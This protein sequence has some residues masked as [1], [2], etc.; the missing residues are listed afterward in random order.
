MCTSEVIFMGQVKKIRMEL[1]ER[2]DWPN[3]LEHKYVCTRHFDDPYLNQILRRY[4]EKEE[5]VCS[6]CGRRGAVCS[7]QALMEQVAWKIHMY[8]D[9]INNAGLYYADSFYDD[10][11][12]IIAGFKRVGEYVAP[13]EAEYY[14]STRA[15]MEDLGLYTE[16]EDLNEDIE[17][18]FT[19]QE[20]IE[21]DIL[22]E[23]YGKTLLNKWLGFVRI[24]TH[25]RRFTFL[26]TPEFMPLV[27]EERPEKEMDILSSLRLLII[28]QKLIRVLP[29]GVTL[30]RARRV[31]EGKK[32]YGFDDITSAPD[33]LAS[34]NRMSPAG[35][36]MFYSSFCMETA[37]TECL[38][39][40]KEA[41]IL[42]E[43]STMRDLRVLDL[44]K[45]PGPS[46]WMESW[47]ENQFLHSFNCEVTKRLNPEDS[48][49]LQYIPTQVFTEY[50]RYMFV[51]ENGKKIDGVVYGSAK[52]REQN[53]VLFCNQKE[54]YKYV[55]LRNL[56]CK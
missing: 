56:S 11:S 4:G 10:E 33:A 24:V 19:T 23:D 40:D 43:F 51:D 41:L 17:D 54:S 55:Y 22:H 45:I 34:I 21:R 52:T 46:F 37:A 2:G 48:N 42:G 13:V 27:T 25:S 6:Y 1:E 44:T 5:R 15:L 8:Y 47:Q 3:G 38:G 29:K 50:L 26:A 12:E 53:V 31:R 36:S 39:D 16:D 14:D 20:W 49:Q 9:D 7:M 18:T 35:I 32:K 28:E 30:Y